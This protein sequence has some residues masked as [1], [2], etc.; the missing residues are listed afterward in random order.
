[1]D[2]IQKLTALTSHPKSRL[3]KDEGEKIMISRL[4][5]ICNSAAIN[6]LF[7]MPFA[8][9]D[10][11]LMTD[12]GIEVCNSCG[13]AFVNPIPDQQSWDQYYAKL[14]KYDF[15]V[16][17]IGKHDRIRF[18]SIADFLL[19][20]NIARNSNVLD[21]GCGSGGLLSVLQMKGFQNLSGLEPSLN[22]RSAFINDHV[23]IMS[24][25]IDHYF[26]DKKYDLIILAEVLEHIVDLQSLMIKI[27]CLQND[28]GWLFTSVPDG[29]RFTS[30][31]DGPFQQFSVEHINFFSPQLL[32]RLMRAHGYTCVSMQQSQ[33]DI[34]SDVQVASLMMLWQKKDVLSANGDHKDE[35]LQQELKQ[36]IA[37]SQALFETLANVIDNIV[38]SD[39]EIY[40][41]GT[42][43]HT[44]RLMANSDLKYARIRAF[45]DSNPHYQGRSIRKI[46]IISADTGKISP[47]TPILISSYIAQQDIVRQIKQTLKLP[48]EVIVLYPNRV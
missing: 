13:M 44:L 32:K 8:D 47:E 1:M 41:W 30:C 26:S 36:Y 43:T 35:A 10:Y 14:S 11:N 28:T 46:P 6:P 40:I 12:Y 16:Q 34:A 45:I 24:G 20:N 31:S 17:Q 3:R 2:Y 23:Q 29:T 38:S 19:T 25:S 7:K 33:Q 37:Q 21:V 4:C 42:G 5:P 27:S 22:V 15:S 48:N 18:N 39:R 9:S